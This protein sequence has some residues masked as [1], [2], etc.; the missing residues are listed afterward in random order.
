MVHDRTRP[1]HGTG[2]RGTGSVHRIHPTVA[3]ALLLLALLTIL[4]AAA[5]IWYFAS[6]ENAGDVA[7][8]WT[9][10]PPTAR[11][12]RPADAQVATP[13]IVAPVEYVPVP[14]DEARRINMLVPL[15]AGPVP[16][17]PPFRIPAS[18]AERDKAAT[19]LA[20]AAYYEAGD[21]PLGQ[22]AVIQVVLNRVAHPAFPANVCGVVFQGAERQT[23]C[24]F[25]F[26]CDGAMARRR[27]SPDAWR[28]A[29]AAADT[30]LGGFVFRPIG[31][32]THYHTDWVVPKWGPELDKVAVVRT[33][34]FFR[35]KGRWGQ[36]DAL[37]E[38]YVGPEPIDP[39]IA[40]LTDASAGE[41]TPETVTRVATG[42]AG[43]ATA[44]ASSAPER[45]ADLDGNI[46]RLADPATN[47][48]FMQVDP[49][50]FPGSYAV[51]AWKICGDRSPCRVAGW[52]SA[53]DIPQRLP[54][55]GDWRARLAFWFEKGGVAGQRS[56][57]DCRIFP[58]DN[59]QQ[60]LPGTAISSSKAAP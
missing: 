29:R 11:V 58:R 17:A 22:A 60:C 6:S 43:A 49:G 25:S 56:Q 28:R 23:G 47:L 51:A 45:T 52:R 13:P 9:G 2:R 48:F 35:F 41:P 5:A 54:L 34:L 19:C 37:R 27:P 26:T 33:H 38:H 14:E 53:A 7:S 20:A 12:Q 59:P 16:P 18:G 55:T 50:A 24:Q 8:T 42:G 44:A 1:R 4:G 46:V 36:P 40:S 21:D 32:A 31:T 15:V 30:A 10:T 57:W 39:G 3:L